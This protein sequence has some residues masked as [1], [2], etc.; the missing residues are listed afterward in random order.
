MDCDVVAAAAGRVRIKS[1]GGAHSR[2]VLV[3]TYHP[4]KGVKRKIVSNN[5]RYG[6][7]WASREQ[8]T[9]ADK[10]DFLLWIETGLSTGGGSTRRALHVVNSAPPL[11]TRSSARLDAV[12]MSKTVSISSK[13]CAP[14][15]VEQGVL[16]CVEFLVK[17]VMHLAKWHV[18]DN[19]ICKRNRVPGKRG[20]KT[21]PSTARG[22]RRCSFLTGRMRAPKLT[23]RRSKGY[24]Y[25]S[26]VLQ[27]L[28]AARAEENLEWLLEQ[29]HRL[30]TL[31]ARQDLLQLLPD[32][33]W[34]SE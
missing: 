31:I 1:A 7:S 29:H 2:F 23:Q 34:S 15:E 14:L 3:S 30:A 27:R 9:D 6:K 25:R 12:K 19:R 5:T 11:A 4:S 22:L 8:I 13:T 18:S 26:A 20:H 21:S 28:A 33:M 24:A 16:Q 17:S 10:Q 32:G